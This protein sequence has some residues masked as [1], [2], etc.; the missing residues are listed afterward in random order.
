MPSKLVD[1]SGAVGLAY[2]GRLIRLDSH[3]HMLPL[4]LFR[5][6]CIHVFA[7]A[8]VHRTVVLIVQK[9]G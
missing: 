8:E 1:L 9:R 3:L 5:L 2:Y 7:T 4:A 6:V